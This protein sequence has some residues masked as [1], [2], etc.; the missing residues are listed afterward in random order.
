MSSLVQNRVK[1]SKG[2]DLM[3]GT[4]IIAFCQLPCSE[5]DDPPR[6]K[7]IGTIFFVSFCFECR[8]SFIIWIKYAKSQSF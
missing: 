8:R 1:E 6:N 7:I 4:G 2:E 3:E 5:R